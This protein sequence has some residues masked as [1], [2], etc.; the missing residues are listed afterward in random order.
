M[1]KINWKQNCC[2]DNVRAQMGIIKMYCDLLYTT[3]KKTKRRWYANV[4]VREQSGTFRYG[5]NRKSIAK[6]KEDAVRLA[7]ELLEDCRVAIEKEL[8]NFKE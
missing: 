7:R 8:S 4:S 3:S 1:K 2:R 5:P 6:A